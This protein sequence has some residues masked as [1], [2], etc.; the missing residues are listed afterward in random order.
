MRVFS[1]TCSNTE[2][3]CALGAAD[4]LVGVD[5]DSD[6]PANVVSKLP[7]LGRD[8]ELDVAAVRALEPDLVLS[9]LTV[10]GHERIVGELRERGLQVYVA[11]PLSLDDV[12]G[13]ILAIGQLLGRLQAAQVLVAEMQQAM[14]ERLLGQRPPVLVEWWPKP[15]IAPA[16]DSWV[17]QLLWKAGGCNPWA[18]AEGKSLQL[19][20]EAVLDAAPQAIV[21]SWCGVKVDKYRPQQVL[22]REDWEQVPA[23]RMQRVLPISEEFLGRPGPRLVQGYRALCAVVDEC[24][25]A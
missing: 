6:Y 11:D 12:Y 21:M 7:K 14:P 4:Q 1:H 2:I 19:A 15:V 18:Q 16:A 9:S 17:N 25:T 23:V 22:K 5:T 24:L 10:P 20:T 8:L 3:V 13:D